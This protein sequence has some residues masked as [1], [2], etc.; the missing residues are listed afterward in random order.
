MTSS[1]HNADDSARADS[2]STRRLQGLINELSIEFISI[3]DLDELVDR[4]AKRLREV[5]DFKFFNLFLVDE[6]RD[7]LVWKK[8]V[9]F[10][11]GEMAAYEFIPLD[12]SIASAAVREGRTIVVGDV[13]L[14]ARYLEIET[15]NEK[16]PRSEIAVPLTLV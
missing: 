9:G 14:D 13:S 11:S 7:G 12:R 16:K 2:L 4:V 3:L 1:S 15:E 6:K 10:K 5:I 8:S